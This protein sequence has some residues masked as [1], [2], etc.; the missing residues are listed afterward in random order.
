MGDKTAIQWT[1]VPDGAGG[2]KRGATWN[3]TTGCVHASPGCD[4][5]YAEALSVRLRAMGSA[6]YANGFDLT[7]HPD[8]LDQPLR[9]AAPRGIFVNSMSD[10][11]LAGIPDAFLDR[12]YAAMAL[13][14]QHTYQVLTKRPQRAVNYLA[15]PETPRN[16]HRAARALYDAHQALRPRLARQ[17][18]WALRE[19]RELPWPLPHVWLGTSV[20]QGTAATEPRRDDVRHRIAALAA[21]PAAVRFLSCEPLIGPLDLAGRLAGI[22][23]VIAGGESGP[24]ARPLDLDWLRAIRDACGAA[25]VAFFLKQIGGR[26]PKSGGRTLDGREWSEYPAAASAAAGVADAG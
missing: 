25:G 26:T 11:F 10:L 19:P 1:E 13:A 22:D 4:H 18:G 16:I 21:A 23:W 12:V 14:P 24:N 15:R 6:K 20:E 17:G 2:S 9:W 8:T 3:P 7:L 5:C